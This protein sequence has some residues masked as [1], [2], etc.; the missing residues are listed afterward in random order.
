MFTHSTNVY[1][2]VLPLSRKIETSCEGLVLLKNFFANV[3]WY[4]EVH[5]VVY[6]IFLQIQ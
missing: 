1:T 2:F 5:H 3:V 4:E 6:I